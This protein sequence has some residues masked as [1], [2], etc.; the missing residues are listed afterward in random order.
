MYTN[1]KRYTLRQGQLKRQAQHIANSAGASSSASGRGHRLR[2][3]MILVTMCDDDCL[4]FVLPLVQE[5]HVRQDLLH[6]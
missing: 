6:A 4:N 5:C 1:L 2:T 3:Y